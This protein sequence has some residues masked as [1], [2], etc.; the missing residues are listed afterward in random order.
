[1]IRFAL[2]VLIALSPDCFAETCDYYLQ[3]FN[4]S[5]V[6]DL[7][8]VNNPIHEIGRDGRTIYRSQY[9]G[10]DVI[11]KIARGM[12]REGLRNGKLFYEQDHIVE[13]R[14]S[15]LLSD[16]SIG[17]QFFGVSKIDHEYV[18][19]IK[20]I[21][22]L[23][24]VKGGVTTNPIKIPQ[25][26]IQTLMDQLENIFK[27]M[28]Q[29]RIWLCDFQFL[30]TPEYKIVVIDPEFFQSYDHYLFHNSNYDATKSNRKVINKAKETILSLQEHSE[31][32]R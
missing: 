14:H 17:P 27:L 20:F 21:P 26:K 16:L 13:A 31:E 8:R 28:D 30:I 24:L 12:N 22:N 2:V 9:Q 32:I 3:D 5:N 6:Y 10:N 1:M 23:T 18:L 15:K 4:V 25:D 11:I 7:P 29:N 19:I